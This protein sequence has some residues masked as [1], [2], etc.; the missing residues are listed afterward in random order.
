MHLVT[1][2]FG[3]LR[4]FVPCIVAAAIGVTVTVTAASVMVRRDDNDAERQFEVLAE[5]HFMVLQN[6]L[7]EYVNKLEAVRALFDSSIEPVKRNEFV[8]FTR[9]LL[10]E[11]AA[12]ATLSWVP[13]VRNSERTQH[14]R[15][16]ALEGLPDYHIK[17]MTPGGAMITAPE[18]GEYYPIYYATVPRTS[19]LYGLDLRSE[20]E[21]LT[22]LEH[23]R[24]TDRLGFSPVPALV[25]SGG[26][27]GGFLFSLPVYRR[28]ALHDR[29]KADDAISPALCMAR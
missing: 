5:N 24:D 11:N 25:S 16:G 21:T 3:K 12:I 29:S 18:R 15:Q 26:T 13:R 2:V 22:E 20:P 14:E 17:D 8:A 7:D 4:Q 23:A 6:G 1:R 9:P 28:G 19:P 27:H 10:H